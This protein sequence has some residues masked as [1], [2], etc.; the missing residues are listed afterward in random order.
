[1]YKVYWNVD[2]SIDIQ[3]VFTLSIIIIN[4]VNNLNDRNILLFCTYL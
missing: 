2:S 3:Y 4:G 1:M